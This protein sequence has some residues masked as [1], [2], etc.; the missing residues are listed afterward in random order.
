MS[1]LFTL[2]KKITIK[3]HL[4]IIHFYKLLDSA[5]NEYIVFQALQ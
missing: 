2:L 5:R 4:D 1:I 3:L